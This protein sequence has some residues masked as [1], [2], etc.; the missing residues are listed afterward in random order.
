MGQ[1]A[2]SARGDKAEV[3][4]GKAYFGTRTEFT[5]WMTPLD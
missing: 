3:A 4:V 1:G 5:T 2:T